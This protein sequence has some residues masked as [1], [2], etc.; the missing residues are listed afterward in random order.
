[1]YPQCSVRTLLVIILSRWYVHVPIIMVEPPKSLIRSRSPQSRPKRRHKSQRSRSH[2]SSTSRSRSRSHS[3]SKSHSRSPNG[4]H[5]T[6]KEAKKPAQVVK[7]IPTIAK[8][9]SE[10]MDKKVKLT[11]ISKL[12]N[13]CKDLQ[14][15]QE[16]ENELGPEAAQEQYPLVSQVWLW[17]SSVV[18]SC[19][20]VWYSE[21]Y[22][23]GHYVALYLR[24]GHGTYYV[25]IDLVIIL[26]YPSF[27][28]L[29]LAL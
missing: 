11:L 17:A 2:S 8:G 15:K 18:T 29:T 27:P 12:T 24:W 25:Q 9:L 7:S 23:R 28:A 16:V 21:T 10:K 3:R 14:K 19:Q 1:M 4:K 6:T 13:F 22:H 26:P 20:G 5:K